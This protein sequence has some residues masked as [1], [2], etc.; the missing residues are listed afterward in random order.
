MYV[1]TFRDTVSVAESFMS[2]FVPTKI[3]SI[4]S[5]AFSFSSPTQKSIASRDFCTC[6]NAKNYQQFDQTGA[7]AV[8]IKLNS[9][10]PDQ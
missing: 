9:Y 4:S 2:F 7:V 8:K 10:P 6:H 1:L 5:A 3:I